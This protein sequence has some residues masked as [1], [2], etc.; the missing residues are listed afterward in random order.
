MPVFTGAESNNI[1]PSFLRIINHSIP[2]VFGKSAIFAGRHHCLL[3][4]SPTTAIWNVYV[5]SG[6]FIIVIRLFVGAVQP[7]HV[8]VAH[9]HCNNFCIAII[10]KIGTPYI[11][12]KLFFVLESP[13]QACKFLGIVLLGRIVFI[14]HGLNVGKE[15][16]APAI[17]NLKGI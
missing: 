6:S 3:G 14:V 9:K 12:L 2:K 5:V 10:A 8:A 13:Y 15:Q 17:G 1:Y 4:H 7:I 16:Y 11:R